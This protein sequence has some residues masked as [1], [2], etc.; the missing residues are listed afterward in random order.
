MA[1]NEE[2]DIATDE[3]DLLLDAD[4][5]I[6]P[7]NKR[8]NKMPL[9]ILAVVLIAGIFVFILAV[10]DK[11]IGG[12]RGAKSRIEST[13]KVAT[14][15]TN[16][17][18]GAAVI[19][20]ESPDVPPAREE[21]EVLV[22]PLRPAGLFSGPPEPLAAPAPPPDP[23]AADRLRILQAQQRK[24]EEAVTKGTAVNTI[25]GTGIRSAEYT[26]AVDASYSV[27]GG[28]NMKLAQ[29]QAELDGMGAEMEDARRDPVEK[30]QNEI[31]RQLAAVQRGIGVSGGG[32]GA[33]GF[34]GGSEG[35]GAGLASAFDGGEAPSEKWRIVNKLEVPTRYVIQTGFSI[36]ALL[37]SGINSDLPG[38]I[39][40]QVSQ[41]VYDTPTGKWLLIPQGT[42]LI[43]Q[44]DSRVNTTTLNFPN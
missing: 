14:A 13:E 8:A 36:P 39:I 37:V 28:I 41:N 30:Y 3:A 15:L 21:P 27:G 22:P 43:G 5:E 9:L 32:G 16:Q 29:L 17:Y 19:P 25:R 20:V 23:L 4:A 40:A 24:Y 26:P 42:K 31:Q 18:Q 12:G 35:G 6:T 34:G 44:Y 1:E 33:G 38:M 7:G 10:N 2:L 11:D